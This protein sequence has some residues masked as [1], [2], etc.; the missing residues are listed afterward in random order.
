[1]TPLQE[2]MEILG[3]H[4]PMLNK[5]TRAF[6]AQEV[7]RFYFVLPIALAIFA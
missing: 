5:R 1:M 6:G 3:E 2:T 7:K 4:R